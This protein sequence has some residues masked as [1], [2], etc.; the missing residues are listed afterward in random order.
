MKLLANA[1]RR[2]WYAVYDSLKEVIEYFKGGKKD[3]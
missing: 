1:L 2:M 3:A